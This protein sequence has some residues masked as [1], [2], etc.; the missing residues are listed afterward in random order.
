[1][2][3]KGAQSAATSSPKKSTTKNTPVH[4]IRLRNIS[5]SIWK[6]ATRTGPQYAVTVR[7]FWSNQGVWQYSDTFS[8]DDLLVVGELTRLCFAWICDTEQAKE[9]S[10]R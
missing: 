5:G 6:N 2:A 10:S 8:R 1:M 7:K 3:K 9:A 4:T